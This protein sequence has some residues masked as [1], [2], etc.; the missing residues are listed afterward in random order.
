MRSAEAH[1]G[2]ALAGIEH[3]FHTACL[4]APRIRV[5]YAG[6]DR[7]GGVFP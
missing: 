6:G 3:T 4:V 2:S 7:E 1:K 5:F